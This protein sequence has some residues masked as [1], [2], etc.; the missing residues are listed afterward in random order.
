[1]VQVCIWIS[2]IHLTFD[3]RNARTS[4]P[5]VWLSLDGREIIENQCEVENA[6]FIMCTL[7][8]VDF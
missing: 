1:M 6:V 8:E 5:Q 7:L 2:D 3:I 4:V